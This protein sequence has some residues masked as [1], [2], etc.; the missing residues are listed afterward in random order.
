MSGFVAPVSWGTI[1]C[2]ND[3]NEQIRLPI[4]TRKIVPISGRKLGDAKDWRIHT[5]QDTIQH[6]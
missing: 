1:A 6:S 2:E 3:I 5:L 4:Y